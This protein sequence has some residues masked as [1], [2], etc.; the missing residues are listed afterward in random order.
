M[1]LLKSSLV[2]CHF[3]ENGDRLVGPDGGPDRPGGR[4]RPESGLPEGSEGEA[5]SQ[6]EEV[7]G[8]QRLLH[9]KDSGPGGAET[10]FLVFFTAKDGSEADQSQTSKVWDGKEI[11]LSSLT[12]SSIGTSW[13]I[14]SIGNMSNKCS[15]Y[16]LKNGLMNYCC[17]FSGDTYFQQQT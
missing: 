9:W 4:R 6:A 7:S 10:T 3:T 15:F 2:L 5:L 17:L 13:T 12:C 11:L 8:T 16:I 1:T 14:S